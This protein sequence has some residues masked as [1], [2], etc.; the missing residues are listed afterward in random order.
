MNQKRQRRLRTTKKKTLWFSNYS[1]MANDPEI[2]SP[3]IKRHV[4]NADANTSSSPDGG[5]NSPIEQVALTVPV[6]DDPS[7]PSFTFRTWILGT[8]ACALLSFLN[9][10][11][12]YRRE[13]L[14]VTAISAQ[15]AVVPAG[16]LMAAAVTRRVFMR[17]TK[18]EFTLNPGKFNVKEH[19]L[20]TIF[21]SSGAASVYAIHFVSAVKVFYRK[22]LT[23]LAALLVVITTQ[24]LGFGWAGVF[25]RYLVEPATMWWPQNLVQV[26][27]FRALHEQE[28]RPKGGLTRNQFF[29]IAFLCSFAYYVFPG[30]LIPM[31]TS[32]SW[33]CWVFPTSVIAHQLGSGL[34]GLGLGAI[35]FDWSSICSYLGS[36]LASPWFATANVAAG[37]AIFMY[38]IMPI[39]Y[40]TNLYKARSFPIFSDD[41]FMS[42]GQKYNISAITDSKFHLDMEAYEREGP[43][44]LSTMFAMSYGI[45]FACLSATLVHV[46][47]FHGSEIWRLSKSA[48]QENKIDIHTKIMRKHY[49]QVPE[50]WFL[51]ILLFNITATIFICEYFNNQL[52][53]PWWGVVLACIVAISFTLPVG[54]IRATT[55]QAPALN[56]ITEYII[57]Y[58]YPGYPVAIML[59]KVYGNVSMKQAI[60][61]LQDFKLG[62]Y[63]KIPPREMFFAQVLGT[64]ISAVVHLLTA[65]WLMNTVPNICERELLPAGSPWTC[66]GDHVFYDASVVWGLIGPR[67]IFGDLGHYSAINWFFLAG[68]IA[69]FLVWLAHKA[70]PNKQ[71]IRLITVPVL[72]GALADMPPATA[73]NYTSWVLVGFLS[74]F[75]VYRYYRDW[76]SRHNYVLSGALD[77]GLAFMGVLLYLCL[78]MKQISLNWWGSD[79]DGCP[80][81]S[82]PTSPGVES[83]GCSV[84]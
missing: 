7:L 84:Y 80:L 71:W 33:I 72:L 82:C 17:G 52:Q 40:W 54:V 56:I 9:Q 60:F 28:K 49:K 39:A 64:L 67:R 58:I 62:H 19:V 31:L 35:G 20:I 36:P 81:A 83:K 10:F 34:H 38:V 68:A 63:M 48:F 13:P 74:G 43:L 21:A 55:N 59:F 57:G 16:H 24:V 32:I 14:S 22:E 23:V 25:R 12:G 61:F 69:P 53:L 47:L 44:Y 5:E 51:C 26:S 78:G 18:W 15:I 65:W 3:L 27:L 1:T 70:F 29:L 46:L 75:V 76:W 2:N 6:G 11:F 66:P 45:G 30:Y 37:F 79:P 77:A 73:V 41:L 42:N 50:W 4:N 8:L